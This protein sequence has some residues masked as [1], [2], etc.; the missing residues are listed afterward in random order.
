MK[1]LRLR[2]VLEKLIEQDWAVFIWGATGH[3]WAWVVGR[4]DL[5]MQ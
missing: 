1:A 4:M 5:A 2:Q 3:G